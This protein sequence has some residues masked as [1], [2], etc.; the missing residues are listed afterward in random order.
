LG[1]NPEIGQLLSLSFEPVFFG[2]LAVVVVAA[3][4]AALVV[5]PRVLLKEGLM[6]FLLL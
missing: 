6:L 4:A 3:A 5:Q 1:L 2:L